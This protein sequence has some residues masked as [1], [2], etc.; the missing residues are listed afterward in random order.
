MS[1]CTVWMRPIGDVRRHVFP[2]FPRGEWPLLVL[3]VGGVCGGVGAAL[4]ILQ[5]Q[6][7]VRVAVMICTQTRGRG[8]KTSYRWLQL[9]LIRRY[10]MRAIPSRSFVSWKR[11]VWSFRAMCAWL[12]LNPSS[13]KGHKKSAYSPSCHGRNHSAN[14]YLFF[15]HVWLPENKRH[16]ALLALA[17]LHRAVQGHTGVSE[18]KVVQSAVH[19]VCVAFVAL[20]REKQGKVQRF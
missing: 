14:E 20:K 3:A 9:K 2:A 19:V 18:G 17:A 8:L 15:I 6:V 13:L 11:D 16:V 4:V 7:A 5:R 1:T 10:W 12:L